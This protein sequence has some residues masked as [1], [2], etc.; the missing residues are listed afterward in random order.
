MTRPLALLPLLLLLPGCG[1]TVTNERPS[2]Q[3]LD[4]TE[5]SAVDVILSEL[6]ALNAQIK[7]RTIYN[8]DEIVNRE[9]IDVS[10]EGLIFTGNIGDDTVHVAVWENLKPEQKTLIQGWFKSASAAAA[11]QT[12]KK[13]FYQ[14]LA[15][16]QG[17]KQYVYKVV[18]PAWVYG[19][20]TLFSFERDSARTALAHYNAIG[21]HNEMWPF[22]TSTCTPVIQQ[23]G[24][25]YGP[26]F[27]KAYLAD[28]VTELANPENPTG[29]MYFLC[30][31]IEESKPDVEDLTIEL[32]WL[33]D[34][35]K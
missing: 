27:N 9:R 14:F 6:T 22:L 11:E 2:Y 1:L 3:D 31:W 20:R 15:V 7:K 28:H 29:Y 32:N 30:R 4:P 12:Y 17:V 24:A 13:L 35:P 23:Y 8:I 19:H 25:T 10:F 16:S 21:R 5:K 26:N 33:R 18:T 34:L